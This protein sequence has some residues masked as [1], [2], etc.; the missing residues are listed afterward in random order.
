MKPFVGTRKDLALWR[1][2]IEKALDLAGG[3]LTF[4]NVAA[5]VEGGRYVMMANDDSCVLLDVV[6]WPNAREVHVF[7]GCG[8][9]QGLDALDAPVTAFARVVGA[10]RITSYARK[11]FTHRMT[12]GWKHVSNIY[13]KEL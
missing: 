13:A 2:E 8:T 7:L 5:R 1:T 6:D 9:Q 12:P 10:K 11:G 3:V 4:D